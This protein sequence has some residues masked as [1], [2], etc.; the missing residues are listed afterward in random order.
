MC[1][2]AAVSSDQLY[3]I[4]LSGVVFGEINWAI[5]PRRQFLIEGA[6]KAFIW[7]NT[8]CLIIKVENQVTTIPNGRRP[9]ESYYSPRPR[10]VEFHVMPNWLGH[11]FVVLRLR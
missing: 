4:L 3:A 10:H 5:F 2:P 7:I 9:S 6:V 8:E 11:M 1:G